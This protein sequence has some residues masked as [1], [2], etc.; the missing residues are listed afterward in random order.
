MS[1]GGLA[2]AAQ[3]L[4]V[5]G[6]GTWVGTLAVALLGRPWSGQ[7][8][9]S[10]GGR[11]KLERHAR[12]AELLR[13][14]APVAIAGA[15][16][17]A[18][19]GALSAYLYLPDLRDLYQTAW[20]RTLL[21]KVVCVGVV[22]ALGFRN[23]RHFRQAPAGADPPSLRLARLELLAALAVVLLTGLLAGLPSPGG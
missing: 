8:A 9:A 6:A 4:H 1:H 7:R 17:L 23:F 5:L 13:C 15:A 2:L 22:A 19:S 12:T 3:S 21:L 14:F 10:R 11:T 18:A 20:G 16:S